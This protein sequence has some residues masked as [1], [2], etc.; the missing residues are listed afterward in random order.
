[1]L[2]QDQRNRLHILVQLYVEELP[3][4][5][6]VDAL[7]LIYDMCEILELATDQL[8]AIL[9]SAPLRLVTGFAYGVAPRPTR[10]GDSG[11]A[12]AAARDGA[13]ERVS[14]RGQW[15]WAGP[16]LTLPHPT[17][18]V[19][20]TGRAAWAITP[21]C[22]P[23]PACCPFPL[24]AAPAATAVADSVD[25]VA[26]GGLLRGVGHAG[27]TATSKANATARPDNSQRVPQCPVLIS[28]PSLNG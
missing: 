26:C 8:E 27:A 19:K 10:V 16:G 2:T 22:P 4:Q 25:G 6:A 23:R 24:S 11:A 20:Q 9:G 15:T 5:A 3:L 12:D 7:L 14:G 28:M 21:C 13:D 17:A 1:M 18:R